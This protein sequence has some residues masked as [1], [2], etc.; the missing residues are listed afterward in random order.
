VMAT[1]SNTSVATAST[2]GAPASFGEFALNAG[3]PAEP[4]GITSG[5]DNALWYTDGGPDN[6]IG[7]VTLAGVVSQI[8]IPTSGADPTGITTGPDNNIWFT[9][10]SG[11]K[12]AVL[13]PAT[14]TVTA[15]FAVPPSG[16]HSANPFSIV[17]GSDG[18]LW[19]TEENTSMIA[20]INPTSHGITSFSTPTPLAVPNRI[21]SGPDGNLWFTE[22]D[23]AKIGKATTGG[24]LTEFSIPTANVFPFDITVGPD[25]ALWFT[26]ESTAAIGRI[27]TAGVISQFPIPG[28]SL[29]GTDTITTGGDGNIWVS[30]NGAIIRVTPNIVPGGTPTFTVFTVSSGGPIVGMTKGPNGNVYLTDEDAPGIGWIN[31]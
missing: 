23:G 4:G 29:P 1:P 30:A 27:T 13:N 18:N 25:G 21:V 28:S 12:I 24:V 15:E 9:E 20:N 17:T 19:F 31:L 14:Q 3:A 8:T 6:T 22:T 5:P 16:G 26:E 10:A 7:R 2:L 11:Q